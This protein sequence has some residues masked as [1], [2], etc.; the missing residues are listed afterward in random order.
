MVNKLILRFGGLLLTGILVLPPVSQASVDAQKK[1]RDIAIEVDRRDE[2]FGDSRALLEMI[3]KD[4]SGRSSVRNLHM[5]TLE[6]LDKYDGDK[7]LV[8]FNKPRDI[9]GTT[10]L[11]F[12]HFQGNDDQWLFL[13][14]LRR[15]KRISS[16]NKSGPFVG[17]EFAYEDLLSQEHQRYIHKWLK[18]EPCGALKCFVIERR[19]T[20]SNSGYSRQTVWIDQQH[21][22]PMRIDYYDRR[23][24]LLKTLHYKDYRQFR[25]KY[26]RAHEMS[27]LNSQSGKSTVLRFSQYEFTVGLKESYFHPSRL[28]SMR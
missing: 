17:S 26:W 13:P 8:Q 22:R 21:Y 25:K 9:A 2:G 19:P 23:N 28:R 18:D 1:G 10:L 15:V 16:N 14:A 12:S 11:S 27:M 3:L 6:V 7:T 5:M 20:D 24:A 4:R